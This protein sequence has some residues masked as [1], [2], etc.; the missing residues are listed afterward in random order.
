[1]GVGELSGGPARVGE[2]QEEVVED[3]ESTG[4]GSVARGGFNRRR[5]LRR[6]PAI[7][8]AIGAS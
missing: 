7:D 4:T 5:L 6:A 1:M 3:E 2:V 8:G